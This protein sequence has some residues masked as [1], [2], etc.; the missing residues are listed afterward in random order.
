MN[1]GEKIMKKTK[2]MLLTGVGIILLFVI[3]T[4]LVKFVDV[5]Q[6]GQLNSSVGFGT[7]N[8]F[9]LDLIGSNNIWYEITE[10]LGYIIIATFV[11]GF[12]TLGIYQLVKR[13]KISLVDYQI[14]VLIGF[15]V[16]LALIYVFFELVVVNYRPILLTHEVELEASYP[17]S[18]TLL[19]LCLVSS[20]MIAI[21]SISKSKKLV[22]A[23][24][25]VGIILI[26]V[27]VIGR[28]LSGVHWFSDILGAIILSAGLLCIFEFV[29]LFIGEKNG[30]KS[31]N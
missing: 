13:K 27:M 22:Y 24:D 19:A 29:I 9:V 28:I 11:F 31:N 14:Y 7:M 5:Q 26:A 8:K 1:V 3:Y 23:F 20:S 10:I 2:N 16:V 18:H 21:S 4:I 17:S 12:G 6:I 15:C 30:N 25:G